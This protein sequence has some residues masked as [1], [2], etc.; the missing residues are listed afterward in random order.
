MT[1]NKVN[2]E[3]LASFC[4]R[5]GIVFKAAEVYGSLAGFF[6]FGPLGVEL[7]NNL[8]NLY[9][10]HFV[11]NTVH[12]EGELMSRVLVYHKLETESEWTVAHVYWRDQL[13]DDRIIKRVVVLDDI[14]FKHRQKSLFECE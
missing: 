7:K 13:R 8:K 10:R 9:W 4:K 3:E 1:D 12:S 11:L 6:D 2:L 14:F 5:K